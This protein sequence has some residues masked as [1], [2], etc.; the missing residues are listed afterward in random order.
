VRFARWTAGIFALLVVAALITVLVGGL[1]LLRGPIERITLEKTGR[2]LRIGSLRPV[3][4]WV[5]PRVRLEHVTFT[6]PDWAKEK[7]L[8]QADA[9]ELTM[10]VLPLAIGR[11]VLPEVNLEHPVVDLEQDGQGR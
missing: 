11:V 4:S 1:N 8:L 2:E 10:S 3:W 7:Y 5:H 9:V 6:N